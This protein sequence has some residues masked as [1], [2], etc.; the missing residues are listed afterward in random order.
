MTELEVIA[1]AQSYLED[2]ANGIDPLTG[3]EVS[4]NDIV[5]NVRISRC[6]FY[7]AGI[8]RQIV[9]NKGKFKVDMPDRKSFALTPEQASRFEYSDYGLSVTEVVKRLN[10]LIDTVY[11]KELKTKDVLSWLVDRGLLQNFIVNNKTR[12]RPTAQGERLGIFTEERSGQYGMYEGVFYDHEAQRFL[13]DNIDA[14]VGFSETEK[15]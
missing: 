14:I 7:S 11:M 1:R 3:R 4:E 10:S 2:L 13:V 15:D 5:N 9:E 6:L 12:R 8:L